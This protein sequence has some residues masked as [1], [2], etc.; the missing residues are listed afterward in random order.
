[1]DELPDVLKVMRGIADGETPECQVDKSILIFNDKHVYSSSF[2]LA[3][4]VSLFEQGK[5]SSCLAA[6][7]AEMPLQLFLERVSAMGI[8]VVNY[9]P[10]DLE[11]ELRAFGLI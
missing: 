5:I 9:D 3:L 1:M 4:A 2:K 6:E 10:A 8:P 11:R 7:M